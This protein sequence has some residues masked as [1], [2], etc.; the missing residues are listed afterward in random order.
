[1]NPKKMVEHFREEWK[2]KEPRQKLYMAAGALSLLLALGGIVLPIVPQV[3]FAILSAYF[4]SKGSKRIHEWIRENR[5][6]GGPVKDW[7]DDRVV[8]PKLKIFSTIAM[9][10][11]AAFGHWKLDLEWAL[12]LDV[13]F[14]AA[15]VFVLT[16]R[17]KKPR[18]KN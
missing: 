3:P 12:A 8:K 6:F 5:F 4:F 13:A 16:R 10:A 15:I 2:E 17:S 11:G 1:M 14:A 18:K 7:E 9:V